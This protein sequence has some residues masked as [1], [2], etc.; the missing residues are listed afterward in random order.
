[1]DDVLLKLS[2]SSAADFRSCAQLFKF[3]AVDRLPEPVSA[4]GARGS[5]VHK[6][7]ERLFLDEPHRRTPERSMELLEEC[8]RE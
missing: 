6:V 1:M 7:L 2:P 8:W 3:R 4:L 5:V